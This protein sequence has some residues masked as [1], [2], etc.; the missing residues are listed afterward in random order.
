MAVAL[1]QDVVNARNNA[2][3]LTSSAGQMQGNQLAVGD[4]LKQK[5]QEAYAQNQDIIKP[6]DVATQDYI[7]SPKVGREKYQD[8]FNPFTREKLVSQY[9]GT[10]ALPMLSLSSILGNR[11]GRIDDTLGAGVR[12]YEAA[13][14]AKINE[15]NAA[16]TLY[17][18]LLDE[19]TTMET[20]RQSDK[21]LSG[22]GDG[23][24]TPLP[25]TLDN[26][27]WELVDVTDDGSSGLQGEPQTFDFSNQT[28]YPDINEGVKSGGLSVQD[29][30]PSYQGGSNQ[31]GSNILNK[32]F[33]I[34]LNPGLFNLF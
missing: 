11:M 16:Q 21:K 6:L 25:T 22:D 24:F 12:G 8:I 28:P 5:V 34:S 23:V 32:L 4:V 31:G 17:K 30:Q 7:Q 20:L 15:A 33:G 3:S 18:N 1:P 19:Y 29:Y 14:T 9:T 27:E 2:Q 13:T 10:T 26:D